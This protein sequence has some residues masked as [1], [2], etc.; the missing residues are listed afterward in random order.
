MVAVL[1]SVS[2][3]LVSVFLPPHVVTLPS[4]ISNQSIDIVTLTPQ[5]LILTFRPVRSYNI[6]LCFLTGGAEA[7]L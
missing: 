1:A 4:H 2:S 3:V 6:L 5:N 7:H